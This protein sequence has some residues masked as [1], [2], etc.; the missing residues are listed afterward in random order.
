MFKVMNSDASDFSDHIYNKI[1]FK[2]NLLRIC[3]LLWKLD[4]LNSG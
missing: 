3:K 1:N 2:L 4:L